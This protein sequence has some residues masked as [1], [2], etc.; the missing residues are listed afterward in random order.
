MGWLPGSHP[1][2]NSAIDL[3]SWEKK[4]MTGRIKISERQMKKTFKLQKEEIGTKRNGNL[5][6]EKNIAD[7][8]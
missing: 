2:S 4:A 3:E 8:K 6:K 1:G 5:A 7:W